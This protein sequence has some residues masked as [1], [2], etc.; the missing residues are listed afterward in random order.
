MV[1][2]SDCARCCLQKLQ[3]PQNKHV[4]GAFSYAL[5]HMNAHVLNGTGY[6]LDYEVYDT[7]AEPLESLRGMT[8]QYRNGTVAFIG[9]EET[10]AIQARLAAAWNLPMITYVSH[11]VALLLVLFIL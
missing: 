7:K 2:K 10:C 5:K 9:P 6:R 4:V 11:T 3:G 8:Q 1:S